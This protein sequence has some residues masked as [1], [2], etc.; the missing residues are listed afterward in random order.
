M[1][2]DPGVVCRALCALGWMVGRTESAGLGSAQVRKV[3]NVVLAA[4]RARMVDTSDEA[5][6]DLLSELRREHILE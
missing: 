2:G 5:I 4:S 1:C 3:E 6:A